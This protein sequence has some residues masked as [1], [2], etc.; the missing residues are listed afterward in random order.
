MAI[1][2][3]YMPSPR[4]GSR[5][6]VSEIERTG[7]TDSVDIMGMP[8]VLLT[9]V[10]AKTGAVRKVPLMR[11][12]HDGLYAAVASLGGAPDHPQWYWNLRRTPELDL[13]DGTVVTRRRARELEGEEREAWWE[14]CVATFPPYASYQRK[15]DRLIPV[16][17]LEPI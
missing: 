10:G 9:M 17:V 13:Q 1:E 4:K 3:E 6:Q 5:D 16:F 7:T 11:V 8:V 2:G 14:R 15:T 12:E